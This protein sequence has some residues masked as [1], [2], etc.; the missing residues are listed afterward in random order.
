MGHRGGH[1][2]ECG[3]PKGTTWAEVTLDSEKSSPKP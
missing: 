1:H 3:M 2:E